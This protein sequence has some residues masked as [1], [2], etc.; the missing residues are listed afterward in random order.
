M[1]DISRDQPAICVSGLTKKYGSATAINQLDL[2]IPRGI[3]FGLLGP[4]GAGKTT[5]IR[6]IMG[7]MPPDGGT[8][9]VLGLDASE[10][11]QELKQRIGYAPEFHHVYRW[12]RIR[13]PE[14]A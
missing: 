5:L 11:P 12:M 2:Q 9:R 3:T 7:Q 13:S 1:I 8:V 10:R 4:N 14:N 6:T